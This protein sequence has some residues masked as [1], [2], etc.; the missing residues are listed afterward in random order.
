M[1]LDSAQLGVGARNAESAAMTRIYVRHHFRGLL[2]R[3]LATCV[4]PTG[5]SNPSVI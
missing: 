2:Q 5:T 4:A 3:F 1:S